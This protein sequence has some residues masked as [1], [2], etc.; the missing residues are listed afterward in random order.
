[1]FIPVNLEEAQES[2]PV[3]GGMY[4]LTI[5]TCDLT[6]TKQGQK[7]QF[8]VGIAIDGHD[9]APAVTHFVGIPSDKDDAGQMRFKMLLLRRFMNLFHIPVDPKGIDT[10]AI[11]GA[12]IGAKAKAELQLSE[13]DDNGNVY[14]RMVVPRLRSEDGPRSAPKPPKR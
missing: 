13:P 3:P 11:G 2:K 1:M 12:L 9:E 6:E 8:K 14:N 7:P 5:T 4:D 10:D